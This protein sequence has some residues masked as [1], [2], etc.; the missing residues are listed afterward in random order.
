MEQNGVCFIFTF[1]S[2]GLAG[3]ELELP[4]LTKDLCKPLIKQQKTNI[5]NNQ[6]VCE[7][8]KKQILECVCMC[9]CVI[10]K[11]AGWSGVKTHF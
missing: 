2:L 6:K 9:V 4:K 3:D 5:Q 11:L 8:T 10:F 7:Q 1:F